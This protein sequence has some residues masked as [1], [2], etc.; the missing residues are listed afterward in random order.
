MKNSILI[1]FCLFAIACCKKKNSSITQRINSISYK[2]NGEAVSV[3]IDATFPYSNATFQDS[4][5]FDIS[6]NIPFSN[7]L[8]RKEAISLVSIVKVVNSQKICA[9]LR[10]TDIK[11]DT[12]LTDSAYQHYINLK[13][14]T[15][16]S[17]FINTITAGDSECEGFVPDSTDVSSNW[18]RVTYEENNYGI[19]D[20]EFNMKLIKIRDCPD[21]NYPDTLYF[22]E[23]KFHLNLKE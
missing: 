5:K 12:I 20:G 21:R 7:G 11:K 2:M 17:R 23:G 4:N 14:A 9:L 18:I 6:F 3:E 19:V 13:L 1:I 16:H 10:P 22:T 15:L 8:G